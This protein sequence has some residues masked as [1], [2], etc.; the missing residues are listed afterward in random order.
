MDEVD[1]ELAKLKK[2]TDQVKRGHMMDKQ[3]LQ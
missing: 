3:E 2:K 1:E